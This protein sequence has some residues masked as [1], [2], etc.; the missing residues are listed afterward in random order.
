MIFYAL[1]E[2]LYDGVQ[3]RIDQLQ[4]SCNQLGIDF[5]LLNSIKIDYSNLPQLHKTDLMYNTARGSQT[6][7]SLLLN[8]NV[9][10]FYI[11]NPD[12]NQRKTTTDWSIIHEK[13]G[14]P[15]PKTVFH[16]T[17]DRQLL[18]R[19]VNYL[20]G[21]PIVIKASGST[22]GIGT[23]K[24]E[25]WQSLISTIDYLLTTSD[26]FILRQF[27]KAKSGCRMIVLGNR[28]I[29]AAEF[30]MNKDDFRNA[31]VISEV[32]YLQRDYDKSVE[33]LAVQ[34]TH[35][36]NVEFAGVDFLEDENNNFLLLEINFPSGF[37]SLI[38][39][40][41]VDI[42]KKMIEHLITKSMSK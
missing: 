32:K 30:V 41:N 6:L 29:A 5:I 39:V 25:S 13:A 18:K 4:E 7:E 2:D 36:A 23:I 15:S 19:Y 9:T 3:V 20:G 11:T 24:I 40:C 21:F 33:Q 10:T 26:K 38:D 16:I 34:A 28:V 31:A 42:P 12:L 37:S 35:L 8:N 27:I 17:N 22:R 14:I 1:Y